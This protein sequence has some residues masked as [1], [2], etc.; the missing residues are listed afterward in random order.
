M[1]LII[2]FVHFLGLLNLSQSG[3]SS[4]GALVRGLPDTLLKQYNYE[5]THVTTGSQLQHSAFFQVYICIRIGEEFFKRQ[6]L[7]LTASV[8]V[9]DYVCI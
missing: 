9:I 8:I 4:L 3:I 7:L 2:I 6:L 5:T 1:C